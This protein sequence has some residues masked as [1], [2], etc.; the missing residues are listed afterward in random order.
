MTQILVLG[1]GKSSGSLIQYLGKWCSS[2]NIGFTVADIDQ[3][4]IEEKTIGLT[5]C[6]K[7]KIEENNDLQL[8]TIVSESTIVVSLL[9]VFMHLKIAKLCIK[10]GKHMAT[11]SYVS[12]EIRSLENEIKEKKLCFLFELGVDPGIDHLSA[13]KLIDEIKSEGGEIESFKSYTGALLHP[14]S[15]EVNPWKYLFTWNPR[16]VVLAGQGSWA[17]FKEKGQIKYLPY[18]RLFKETTSIQLDNLGKFEAYINRDSLEYEKA[19]GLENCQTIIRGTLRRPFFA[20]AWNVLVYLGITS[21]NIQIPIAANTS[22]KTFYKQICGLEDF[23]KNEIEQ[24]TGFF[25]HENAWKNIE[26]LELN[27]KNILPIGTFTPAQILEQILTEKLKFETHH[28]DRVVMCHIIQ[29]TKN[30]VSKQRTSYLS[31]NG[32]KEQTAISSSVGLPLAMGVKQIVQ[33]KFQ[34][35]GIHIPIYKELYEPILAELETF[36]IKFYEITS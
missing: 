22:I 19:F 35:I 1:A 34:K 15:E 32:S 24:K 6:K 26:F 25:I 21:D 18:S 4:L 28:Q 11:A 23:T 9:P 7:V 29:Y 8:E 13:K 12:P 2:Q 17:K 31:I 5:N 3:S 36:G 20:E 14:N 16:N 30:N 10:Y 33:K 27:S